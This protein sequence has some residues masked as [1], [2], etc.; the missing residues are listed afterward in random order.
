MNTKKTSPFLFVILSA[1]GLILLGAGLY[2]YSLSY[3]LQKAIS[4]YGQL[5]WELARDMGATQNLSLADSVKIWFMDN[6]GFVIV[7]GILMIAFS[8]ALILLNARQEHIQEISPDSATCRCPK[9]GTLNKR[10]IRICSD[11]VGDMPIRPIFK[12]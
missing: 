6:H 10:G 9:C 7:V 11:C 2:G 3:Q 4:P 1:I 8:F 5:A 12:N